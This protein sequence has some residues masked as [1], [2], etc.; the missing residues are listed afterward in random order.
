MKGAINV[1]QWLLIFVIILAA[2][3]LSLPFISS[4]LGRSLDLSETNTIT[5]QLGQCNDKIIDTA[6]SGSSN[7]CFFSTDRGF[8]EAKTDGIYYKLTTSSN[9]CDT[10]DWTQ[11]NEDKHV[12]QKCTQGVKIWTYELRWAWYN[13]TAPLYEFEAKQGLSGKTLEINRKSIEATKVVLSV[14]FI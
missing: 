11:I 13:N 14:N 9:V 1:F 8:M 12:W 3:G 2:T 4:S 7:R 5:T 10:H 6:R